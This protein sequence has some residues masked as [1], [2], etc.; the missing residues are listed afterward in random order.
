MTQTCSTYQLLGPLELSWG[1][2][3]FRCRVLIY[4]CGFNSNIG[5]IYLKIEYSILDISRLYDIYQYDEY[6]KSLKLTF[7]NTLAATSLI[8]RG[9]GKATHPQMTIFHVGELL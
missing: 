3:G 6:H 8:K 2:P 5:W 7:A 4:P 9:F 1:S